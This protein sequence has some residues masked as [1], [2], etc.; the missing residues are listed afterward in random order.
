MGFNSL[1]M[2]C[3]DG[4]GA[5]EKNPE[6]F[7][8]KIVRYIGGGKGMNEPFT[9]GHE[10]WAN[11]FQIVWN[12]HADVTGIIAVGGNHASVLGMTMGGHYT[13]DKQLLLLKELARKFGYHLTKNKS[14]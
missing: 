10:M 4:L 5:I 13:P 8:N 1:V 14:K 9:F 6:G 11:H 2:I 7:A 12:Q 3:N